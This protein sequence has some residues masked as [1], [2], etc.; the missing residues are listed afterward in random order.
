M[1]FVLQIRSEKL[2]RWYFRLQIDNILLL[3]CLDE[4][5][6]ILFENSILSITVIVQS[7]VHILSFLGGETW[8]GQWGTRETPGDQG[9]KGAYGGRR[10]SAYPALTRHKMTQ[11]K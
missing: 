7:K 9:E 6:E 2:Y 10:G 4:K 8:N 11:E 3:V 1:N 5:F